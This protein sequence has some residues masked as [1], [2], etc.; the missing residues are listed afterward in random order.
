MEMELTT[1]TLGPKQLAT[2]QAILEF[3]LSSDTE[4]DGF[5]DWQSFLQVCKSVGVEM[6]DIG[7]R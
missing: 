4:E 6:P 5:Y 2:L 7:A 1:I 3:H